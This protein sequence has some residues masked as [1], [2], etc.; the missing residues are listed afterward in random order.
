MLNLSR[1][2]P[3]RGCYSAHVNGEPKLAPADEMVRY[4]APLRRALDSVIIHSARRD[5]PGLLLDGYVADALHN[6]PAMLWHYDE[7]SGNAPS[8]MRTWLE[9]GFLRWLHQRAPP[10]LVEQAERV[11]A[12]AGGFEVL[13]LSGGPEH[14][15]LPPLECLGACLDRL[16]SACLTVRFLRNIGGPVWNARS[17]WIDLDERVTPKDEEYS[18]MCGEVARALLALPAAVVSWPTFDRA[19]FLR[20]VRTRGL[21]KPWRDKFDFLTES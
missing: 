2:A 9:R 14:V 13:G 19:A 21:P 4:L 1:M 5:F 7:A 10:E 8:R 18:A 17:Q 15:R 12:A 6:V 16:K 3:R 20:E 11:I